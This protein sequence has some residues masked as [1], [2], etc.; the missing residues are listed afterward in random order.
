M[1]L[2]LNCITDFKMLYGGFLGRLCFAVLE[3]I[4]ITEN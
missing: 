4:Y 2:V 1:D 3:A